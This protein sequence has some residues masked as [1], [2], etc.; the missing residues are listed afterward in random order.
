MTISDLRCDRCGSPLTGLAGFPFAE[1]RLGV[2][3]SYDPGIPAL[4]DDAGL[5]CE[6]CWAEVSSWMGSQ[7]RGT[8]CSRCRAALDH[9]RLVVSLPGDLLA[10]SLCRSDA[11]EFLNG[12]RTVDPK[13]DAV[14]FEFPVD[15]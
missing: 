10:W 6:S 13:L 7:L 12:L 8:R 15:S 3:F 5:M 1:G 2:R 4:R 11:V 9:G 14:L